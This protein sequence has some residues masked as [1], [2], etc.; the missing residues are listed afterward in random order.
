MRTWI[1]LD[2]LLDVRGF[3]SLREEIEEGV[4][5]AERVEHPQN[6]TYIPIFD[7]NEAA[8]AYFP[9]EDDWH[10]NY[11]LFPGL[12]AFAQRMPFTAL[13]RIIIL[14][15][16]TAPHR[17]WDDDTTQL[18]DQFIWAQLGD[19]RL[20]VEPDGRPREYVTSTFAF[21]DGN[22][23][24]GAEDPT[25]GAISVRVDGVFTE[26]FKRLAGIAGLPFRTMR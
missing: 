9:S 22:H 25:P 8:K 3:L 20:F 24:H 14:P 26:E 17:D 18:L 21:F 10:P 11:K 5:N 4:A 23:I 7:V 1:D 15:G 13:S 16:K 2:A 12:I 6:G 19:K